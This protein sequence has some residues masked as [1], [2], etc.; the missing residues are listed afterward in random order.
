MGS[1][2]TFQHVSASPQS[3]H[4]RPRLLSILG[5]CL[6][7]GVIAVRNHRQSS[8]AP[9]SRP[10]ALLSVDKTCMGAPWTIKVAATNDMSADDIRDRIDAAFA[11]VERVESIMSEWRPDSP[12][13]AINAAAGGAP[14]EVPE[15]LRDII[16]RANGLSRESGG[17]FDIT[18]KGI[19]N[20]W[21]WRDEKFTPPDEERI[22]AALERVG[23]RRIAI[24]GSRVGLKSPGM[25]IG[26]GGIAKGYGVDRAARTLRLAGL[27]NFMI[28]GGGD[29]LVAGAKFGEAWRLGIQHPRNARNDLMAALELADAA[30]VTSG[31][32]EQGR[33]IDGQR[34]HHILDPRTGRPAQ[35]CQSVS[36]I[37]P[38]AESADALA[39][40]LFVLGPEKGLQLIASRP[41]TEALIV[42]AEGALWM[43]E[44]FKAK[45]QFAQP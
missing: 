38:D 10:G 34:I 19:G 35:R 12:V 37:A 32:Y 11:E 15:E 44:G 24:E 3:P 22:Q 23:H 14:I 18:W 2:R 41:R 36:V 29:I 8:S 1:L 43:T 16:V 30:L 20:L 42:D 45:A 33:V 26:L 25:Q 27:R 7:L 4:P 40:T 39:T 13:S 31:D 5:L 28:D 21:R 17:A 9:P 6:L